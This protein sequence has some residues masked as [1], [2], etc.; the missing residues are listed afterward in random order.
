MVDVAMS[1]SCNVTSCAAAAL[2][3]R[4]CFRCGR[5]F[6][7]KAGRMAGGKPA[8]P[9]CGNALRASITCAAC[10]RPTKRPGRSPDHGGLVCEGCR[11]ATTHATCRDCRRHRRVSRRDGDGR[12]LCAACGADAP[13]THVCPDCGITQPGAGQAKCAACALGHRIAA[14]ATSCATSFRHAWARDLFLVFCA[15][16]DTAS[17][18]GNMARRIPGH[19][20]FFAKLEGECGGIQEITQQR[21][22]DLFGA[23]GLRRADLPVRF[24]VGRLALAWDA[25]G[26]VVN[27]DRRRIAVT[28]AAAR[29][30]SWSSDLEAYRK[31]LA[32]GR[33]IKSAM[34]RMY[35]A[36]AS[37][38]LRM[39]GVR[40][41]AEL[42]Q[43]H[44]R[45][46]LH[47]Y[48]GRRTN[49]MRFLSWVSGR[50]GAAFE[51]GKGR[52]T[53]PRKREK[54]TLRRAGRLLERLRAARDQREG[55]ALL[56]AT[57][58]VVHGVPLTKVLSLRPDD[59]DVLDRR[60]VL[61]PSSDAIALAEPLSRA[62]A[63]HAAGQG[64][65]A[66]PGRNK[67]QPLTPSSV[68]HHV[69]DAG[70]M[71][72]DAARN[73]Q[74]RKKAKIAGLEFRPGKSKR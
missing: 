69:A 15:S 25:E 2:P 37:S 27:S 54:A 53:P 23:E 68:D 48:R 26:G 17:A 42:T 39:A 72:P 64:A 11:L 9:S 65:F 21:L 35:V 7:G 12:P 36:S 41:A 31:H 61:W 46:Y 19:A 28:L 22:L 45:R 6:T 73:A 50:S 33:E 29:A 24:I 34:A 13:V 43:A 14:K 55:R 18:P 38:L 3:C 59:W 74:A 30:Q 56:A 57:I 20:A 67:M 47:R 60:T 4:T 62:F 52:R 16:I 5:S 8:C 44:V 58:S 51:V 63:R 32:A 1:I 49:I 71:R 10:E 40:A 70:A 66:F